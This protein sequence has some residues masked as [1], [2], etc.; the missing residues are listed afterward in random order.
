MINDSDVGVKCVNLHVAIHI[1]N[2]VIKSRC[3]V[4][5]HAKVNTFAHFL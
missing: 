3:F 2:D 5:L 1:N 4:G